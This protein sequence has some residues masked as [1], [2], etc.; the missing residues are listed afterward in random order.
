MNALARRQLRAVVVTAF[1]VVV[2][3]AAPASAAKKG[4]HHHHHPGGKHHHKHHGPPPPPP[5]PG[6]PDIAIAPATA[7]ITTAGRT[8]LAITGSGWLPLEHVHLDI[9]P[10]AAACTGAGP[11]IISNGAALGSVATLTADNQGKFTAGAT[12]ATCHAASVTISATG[13]GGAHRTATAGVTLA[14]IGGGGPS[15][16]VSPGTEAETANAGFTAAVV[17]HGLQP[18]GAVKV[19]AVGLR[20]SCHGFTGVFGNGSSAL[21]ANRTLDSGGGDTF[22]LQGAGCPPGTYS[23]TVTET[24]GL[25]RSVSGTLVLTA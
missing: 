23:V 1:V 25:Q 12:G 7:P 15:I 4:H 14:A 9:S 17:V 6:G 24:G 13:D 22:V 8:A 11:S 2:V 3:A 10:L 21:A 19:D 16:T 20:T 18:S 5:P